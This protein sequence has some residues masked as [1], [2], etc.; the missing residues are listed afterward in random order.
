MPNAWIM[1]VGF[2]VYGACIIS[3]T[4]HRNQG[5]IRKREGYNRADPLL[6]LG[7][8]L[9]G[10]A[11]I[12]AKAPFYMEDG[13]RVHNILMNFMV[14]L[15]L[16]LAPMEKAIIRLFKTKKDK[17]DILSPV[18]SLFVFACTFG[19]VLWPSYAGIIQRAMFL[20]NFLWIWREFSKP[21]MA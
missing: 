8:G 12:H 2:F 13:N 21:P 7:L 18:A 3:I 16:A 6:L 4:L 19:M 1:N 15:G 5:I 10:V 9:I 11:L 14:F 17:R 20:V